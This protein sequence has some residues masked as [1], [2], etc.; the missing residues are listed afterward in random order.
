MNPATLNLL[1]SLR[2]E[3]Y[4]NHLQWDTLRKTTSVYNNFYE[5]IGWSLLDTAMGNGE[6]ILYLTEC[7]TYTKWF[8]RFMRGMRLRMGEE[9]RKN[10]LLTPES[11][12]ALMKL[13]EGD[14][15]AGEEKEREPLKEVAYATR[16]L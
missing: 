4:T 16:S 11:L 7:P 12:N 5:A 6:K 1:A 15:E 2:Q 8:S 3:K 9:R 10:A 14:W 13:L